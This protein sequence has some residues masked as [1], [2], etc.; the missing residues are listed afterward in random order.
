MMPTPENGVGFKSKT[1]YVEKS[2][3]ENWYLS[4][5]RKWKNT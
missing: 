2:M 1:K 3:N 4:D 5:A